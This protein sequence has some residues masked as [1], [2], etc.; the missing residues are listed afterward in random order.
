MIVRSGET[1]NSDVLGCRGVI[2]VKVSKGEQGEQG[3][4]R[5]SRGWWPVQAPPLRLRSR[6]ALGGGF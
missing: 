2:Q 1:R 6:Q 5:N 4:D 3:E